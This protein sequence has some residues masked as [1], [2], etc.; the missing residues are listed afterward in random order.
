MLSDTLSDFVKLNHGGTASTA[1]GQIIFSKTN[2]F[3]MVPVSYKVI[4]MLSD[5]FSD[6]VKFNH[7][8]C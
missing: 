1:H 3:E 8:T 7:G 4:K 2:R 6:L 5:T